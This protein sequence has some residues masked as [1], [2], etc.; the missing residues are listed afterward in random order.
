MVFC[1]SV[2]RKKLNLS[3][4]FQLFHFFVTALASCKKQSCIHWASWQMPP[5]KFGYVD[6]SGRPT[7]HSSCSQ[8]RWWWSTCL[9]GTG[10]WCSGRRWSCQCISGRGARRCCQAG[11]TKKCPMW[12][13]QLCRKNRLGLVV[14]CKISALLCLAWLFLFV[15]LRVPAIRFHCH[16]AV[17]FH[18]ILKFDVKKWQFLCRGW[19]Q[20]W[21][22]VYFFRS[23]RCGTMFAKATAVNFH[24]KLCWLLLD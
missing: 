12:L 18:L 17:L 3:L 10:T 1:Y 11:V 6:Y 23:R 22:L 8:V 4:Y 16:T 19:S 15:P 7:G 2:E 9:S 5:R 14:T 13:S 20:N 21:K 24:G